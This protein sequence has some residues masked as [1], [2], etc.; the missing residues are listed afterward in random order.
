M[1]DSYLVVAYYSNGLIAFQEE[2]DSHEQALEMAEPMTGNY[3]V[4]IFHPDGEEEEL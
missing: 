2:V 1:G 3:D 4:V